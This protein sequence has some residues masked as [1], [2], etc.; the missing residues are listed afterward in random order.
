MSGNIGGLSKDSGSVADS[1][2]D[3]ITA[4]TNASISEALKPLTTIWDCIEI[5][6]ALCE[7]TD[8]VFVSD[9][10]C[11]HCPCPPRGTANFFK[12][13][14]ATKALHHNLK[15]PGQNIKLN[16]DNIPFQKK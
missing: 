6:L 16:K 15:N 9:W 13:P 14:N 1:E 2:D 4:G 3:D 11:G 12:H 7:V 8:S 10:T 5:N